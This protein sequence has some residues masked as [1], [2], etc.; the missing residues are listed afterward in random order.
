MDFGLN[1]FWYIY[2]WVAM[3]WE[4]SREFGGRPDPPLGVWFLVVSG[5]F[6]AFIRSF[7]SILFLYLLGSLFAGLVAHH[8][9]ISD[10]R[11]RACDMT[12]DVTNGM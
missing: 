3:A 6:W 5:P 10:F 4:M 1:K 2:E 12:F 11:L 7:V 8:V 9:L